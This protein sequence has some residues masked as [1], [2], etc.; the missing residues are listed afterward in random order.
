MP[1]GN[2][3]TRLAV[4]PKRLM[5]W[6]KLSTGTEALALAFAIGIF[7]KSRLPS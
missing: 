1:Y 6:K 2:E 4:C 7:P 5:E 3:A